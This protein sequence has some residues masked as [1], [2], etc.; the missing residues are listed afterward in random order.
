MDGGEAMS[1]MGEAKRGDA[2][3]LNMRKLPLLELSSSSRIF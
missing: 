1:G 3:V 2:S